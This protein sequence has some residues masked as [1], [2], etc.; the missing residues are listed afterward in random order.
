M[1]S[2]KGRGDEVEWQET[3]HPCHPKLFENC[4]KLHIWETE[5]FRSISWGE[6]LLSGLKCNGPLARKSCCGAKGKPN[7]HHMNDQKKQPMN[8]TRKKEAYSLKHMPK[9]WWPAMWISVMPTLPTV[10]KI[11]A[12]WLSCGLVVYNDGRLV[13]GC[14]KLFITLKAHTTLE[15]LIMNDMF[16]AG[17]RRLSSADQQQIKLSST[18][19]KYYRIN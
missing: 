7:S 13:V 16:A 6:F 15:P 2:E 3:A 12:S 18:F 19:P 9:D 1:L 8:R 4:Q 5:C 14:F 11:N 10:T 17:I